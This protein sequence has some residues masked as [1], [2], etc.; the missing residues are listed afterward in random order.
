MRVY[1]I[2]YKLSRFHPRGGAT[3]LVTTGY[4]RFKYGYDAGGEYVVD[5]SPRG[6]GG[7][8]IVAPPARF[9]EVQN[10]L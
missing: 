1:E 7:Q 4:G 10:L 2:T 3:W 5:A 6:V 9:C 8:E